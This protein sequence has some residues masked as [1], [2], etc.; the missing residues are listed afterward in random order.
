MANSNQSPA[1][2]SPG[3]KVIEVREA[4]EHEIAKVNGLWLLPL[5]QINKRFTAL[6][7]NE[8]YHLDGKAGMC[9][10]KALNF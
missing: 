9:L 10:V 1:D 2:R 5:S 3:L 4:T 6:E 8:Q 7:P